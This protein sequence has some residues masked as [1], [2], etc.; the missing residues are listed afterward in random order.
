MPR[1]PGQDDHGDRRKNQSDQDERAP[2]FADD[3]SDPC[4]FSTAVG[5]RDEVHGA[6][7]EA[8]IE[9]ASEGDQGCQGCPY[10]ELA[11]SQG[12]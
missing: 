9:E 6:V 5:T 11:R 2:P 3:S 12:L 4:V 1:H 10:S 7:A 8:K